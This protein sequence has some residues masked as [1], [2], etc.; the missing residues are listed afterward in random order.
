[1]TKVCLNCKLE[2]DLS[3]FSGK[4]PRC[5]PCCSKR[6]CQWARERPEKKKLLDQ[7]CRMA[8]VYGKDVTPEFKA[9][10]IAKQDNRCAIC[11][12]PFD[13]TA[14]KNACLDHVHGKKGIESIRA[15]LCVPC[16]AGIGNFYENPGLLQAAIDY[17]EEYQNG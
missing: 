12:K 15:I 5:K 11:N 13:Q 4:E 14:R 10:L 17:L 7:R 9:M 2:K 3:C 1:M 8:S 16:N 6:A